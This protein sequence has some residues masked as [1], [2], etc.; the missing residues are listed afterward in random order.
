MKA[1]KDQG[2]FLTVFFSVSL[3]FI[4]FA[5]IILPPLISHEENGDQEEVKIL[6]PEEAIEKADEVLTQAESALADL[7]KSKTGK[8]KPE[9]GKMDH[10]KGTPDKK[11]TQSGDKQ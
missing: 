2:L 10:G 7:E 1:P 8:S 3:T 5:W 4:L 11:A 6:K 9:K